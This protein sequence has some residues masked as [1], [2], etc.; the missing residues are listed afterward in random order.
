[1]LHLPRLIVAADVADAFA[2]LPALVESWVQTYPRQRWRTI[3]DV[4]MHDTIT[5]GLRALADAPR[6]PP[7]FE[8]PPSEGWLEPGIWAPP[9]TTARY[10][11]SARNGLTVLHARRSS[12][13]AHR[14]Q[15]RRA[16]QLLA[17]DLDER[18]LPLLV[19]SWREFGDQMDAAQARR[20]DAMH[21]W[22]PDPTPP[23]PAP[24]TKGVPSW[25]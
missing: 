5:P 15:T 17:R 7:R 3:G 12:G 23:T 22:A 9:D 21:H 4:W 8:P 13:S 19:A 16:T 24:L 14:G 20:A 25:H 18:L 2:A 1:V 11:W 10:Y 6:T